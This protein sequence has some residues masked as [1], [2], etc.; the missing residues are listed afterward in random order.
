MGYWEMVKK[1]GHSNNE[2]EIEVD[3]LQKGETWVKFG[4]VARLQKNE[5]EINKELEREKKLMN[6]SDN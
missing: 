6:L 2:I 1:S 3:N 4:K 5:E